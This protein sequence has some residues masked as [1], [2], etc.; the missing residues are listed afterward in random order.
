MIRGYA[1]ISRSTQNI[2]RQIRNILK[3]YPE[4]KIYQEAYTGTKVEGRK[5]FNKLL[6]EVQPGDTIV[7]DSVSRM[8][9]NADEG[10]KIYFD[11]YRMGVNLVFLKESYINTDV[12]KRASQQKLSMTGEAVDVI[13]EG[14]NKY[15]EILAKEQ[16]RIAF[17]QA[18]KEVDDLHQRTKEGIET[19][20]RS[21]KQIGQKPGAKLHIK[22]KAERM[23]KIREKSKDF[24]GTMTDNEVIKITGISRGTYYKY[25]K[26]LIEQLQAEQQNNSQA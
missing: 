19:A 15:F 9:R 22:N 1:R 26:E 10:I 20:R 18:Q 12:Y 13:L 17:N 25:K 2:D 21:G 4:A 3:E 5:L 24:N 6:K 8:S 7:F 11:L 14:I 23:Q 16:I